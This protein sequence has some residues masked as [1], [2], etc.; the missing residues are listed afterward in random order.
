MRLITSYHRSLLK[1]VTNAPPLRPS[2][3]LLKDDKMSAKL[4]LGRVAVDFLKKPNSNCVPMIMSTPQ[5][6]TLGATILVPSPRVD[7]SI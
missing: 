3:D 2:E 6:T 7:S 5:P 1:L 4:E